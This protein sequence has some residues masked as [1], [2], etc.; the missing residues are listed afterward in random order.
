[1]PSTVLDAFQTSSLMFMKTLHYSHLMDEK[2]ESFRKLAK[3]Q[4]CLAP[5]PAALG[6]CP[7]AEGRGKG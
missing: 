3:I 6:I 2:T 1:M 4:V 7:S 5:K